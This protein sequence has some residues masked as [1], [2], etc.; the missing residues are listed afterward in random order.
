MPQR[1]HSVSQISLRALRQWRSI[2]AFQ[3]T[4]RS[5]QGLKEGPLG[6]GIQCRTRPSHPCAGGTPDGS[7]LSLAWGRLHDPVTFHLE[8]I[9]TPGHGPHPGLWRPRFRSR[10]VLH[11]L[12]PQEGGPRRS[13]GRRVFIG[14]LGGDTYLAGL[15]RPE[16]SGSWG[17]AQPGALGSRPQAGGVSRSQS[18]AVRCQSDQSDQRWVCPSPRGLRCHGDGPRPAGVP[19]LPPPPAPRRAQLELAHAQRHQPR[20]AAAEMGGTIEPG[21]G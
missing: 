7:G 19:Q 13:G 10:L 9:T 12:A 14:R 18:E 4:F 2:P 5:R 11:S 15:V 17:P 3:E 1:R 20:G 8:S 6:A 16:R 21:G